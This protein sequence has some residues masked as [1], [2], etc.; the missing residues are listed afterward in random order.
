[1]SDIST[2]FWG[3]KSA[4]VSSIYNLVATSENM[5]YINDLNYQDTIKKKSIV[6]KSKWFDL[7]DTFVFIIMSAS[8]IICEI[9]AI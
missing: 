5:A 2:Q 9:F 1:M 8:F 6:F 7:I 4:V 3:D